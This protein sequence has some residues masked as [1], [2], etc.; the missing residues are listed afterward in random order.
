GLS[1]VSRISRMLALECTVTSRLGRGSR[2]A[3]RVPYGTERTVS[4]AF[5][6][7]NL[8]PGRQSLKRALNVIV[9][10]DHPDV[11]SGMAAILTKWGHR[12]VTAST[13]TDAVVQ[14]IAADLQPDLVISDYHLAAGA[15]GDQAILEVQKEFDTAP[16]ALIITSDP[17]P[18]LRDRLQRGGMTVLYKPLN[19]GKLRA[20]LDRLH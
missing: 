5:D 18:A 3:V 4:E 8:A 14:L 20:M 15:K 12:P 11:L 7:W 17:D 6:M 13:A 19:L 9:I 1:I 16:P 2:F 10:D